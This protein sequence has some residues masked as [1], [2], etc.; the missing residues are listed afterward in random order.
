M[1][2]VYFTDGTEKEFSN[3]DVDESE[4]DEDSVYNFSDSEGIMFQI[5]FNFV[6]YIEW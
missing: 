1:V 2:K 4:L 6:K 5:N 3:V